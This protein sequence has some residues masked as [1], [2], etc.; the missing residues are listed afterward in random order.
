MTCRSL[1][2]AGFAIIYVGGKARWS[3]AGSSSEEGQTHQNR[4]AAPGS[5]GIRL[6]Q[7]R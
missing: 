1:G 5:T 6:K 2:R 4:C 7:P 3:L